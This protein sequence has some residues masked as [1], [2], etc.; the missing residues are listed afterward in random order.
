MWEE[1]YAQKCME[2]K[3]EPLSSVHLSQDGR[4]LNL[5]E[6]TL[7]IKNTMAIVYALQQ[8]NP[9]FVEEIHLGESYCSD[10]GVDALCKFLQTTTTVNVLQLRGSNIQSRG[11]IAIGKLLSVNRTLEKF[12]FF[13]VVVVVFY[14]F[15]VEYTWNGIVLV[16]WM[17]TMD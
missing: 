14:K 3:I 16:L 15:F 17:V 6:C 11:T 12:V 8:L 9:I 10:E 2:L 1:W 5:N 13:F 4:V 7:G